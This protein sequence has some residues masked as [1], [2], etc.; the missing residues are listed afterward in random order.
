MDNDSSLK[1]TNF[2]A[3]FSLQERGAKKKLTKRNAERGISPSADGEKGFA[4]FTAQAFEK[5]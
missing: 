4:P 2:L 5:A 1:S 3:A